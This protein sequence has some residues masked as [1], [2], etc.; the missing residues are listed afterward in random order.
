MNIKP[1]GITYEKNVCNINLRFKPEPFSKVKLNTLGKVRYSKTGY[2]IFEASLITSSEEYS[3]FLDE[4]AKY[5]EIATS[6]QWR[7]IMLY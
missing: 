2:I 1:F 5:N 3:M 4:R 6:K 7:F